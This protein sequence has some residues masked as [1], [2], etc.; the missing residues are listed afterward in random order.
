MPDD[1][2]GFVHHVVLT[3]IVAD[4]R[5]PSPARLA[6]AIGASEPEAVAAMRRL[7]DGHGLVLHPGST[8]VWAAH[9][10]SLVPTHHWVETERRGW[11]APCVWCALGVVALVGEPAC[12]YTRLGGESEPVV[13]ECAGGRVTP[14]RLV[15]HFPVPVARAWDNVHRFC[16]SAL[17]FGDEA[18]V[19]GWCSRH[20]VGRGDVL[21]LDTVAALARLWYGGH[22]ARDWKK[23]TV[24]EARAIFREVGLDGPTWDLPEASGRF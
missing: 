7:H 3:S 11:W 24:A 2:D 15:A 21:P 5:A 8:D 13:L 20:G 4:G 18:A 17:V 23:W 12:I 10:F 14:A 1:I 19:V 16:G 22:L 6:A 9:P